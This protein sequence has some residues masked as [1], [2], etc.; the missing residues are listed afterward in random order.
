[1]ITKGNFNMWTD[2]DAEY[3]TSGATHM[4]AETEIDIAT[5]D[6]NMTSEYMA[7][8]APDGFVGGESVDYVGDNYKGNIF[9][10][11]YFTGFSKEAGA[12]LTAV[13]A[14]TAVPGVGFF[15]TPTGG[16]LAVTSLI[17]ATLGM[18]GD[19]LNRSNKGIL[20]V[21]VDINNKILENVDLREMNKIG[22]NT[23]QKS[24]PSNFNLVA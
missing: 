23:E 12:A 20:N 3:A 7:I 2:G 8:I 22:E 10:G 11:Q 14:G 24:K 19:T 5:K 4:S 13:T 21:D 16:A 18:V 15:T 17:S 1:M 6:F 9:D